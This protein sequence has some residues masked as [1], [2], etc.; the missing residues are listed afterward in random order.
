MVRILILCTGNYFRSRFAEHWF[1]HCVERRQL[2]QSY[3]A[4]SAGLQVEACSGNVGPM[5]VEAIAA[6]R[7]RGLVLDPATLSMPRQVVEGDLM[8]AD[9]IVAV[10][11][12]AHRPMVRARFPHWEARI[13]F[14]DVKDLGEGSVDPI[15]QLQQ[16]V[17][18]LVDELLTSSVP[19]H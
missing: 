12:E 19:P 2:R 13:C 10:D 15:S 6:L 18:T 5:A 8:V 11:A 16:R 4:V 7:E 9:A 3:R 14:W 1:N 17:E